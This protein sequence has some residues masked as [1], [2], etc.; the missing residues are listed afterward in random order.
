[1][2]RLEQ[3]I[4]TC[5]HCIYYDTKEEVCTNDKG[6]RFVDYSDPDKMFCAWGEEE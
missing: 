4:V 5:D 6:L 1:M 2:D 3:E